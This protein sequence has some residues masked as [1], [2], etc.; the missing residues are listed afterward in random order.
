MV[1]MYAVDEPNKVPEVQESKM[2]VS[3]E[4]FGR[5][6]TNQLWRVWKK[7]S[8]FACYNEYINIKDERYL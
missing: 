5:P 2:A 7:M 3:A 4:P 6:L 1:D 8:T